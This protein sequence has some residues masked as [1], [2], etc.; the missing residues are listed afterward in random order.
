MGGLN[1]KFAGRMPEKT[2][3]D[4]LDTFFK[5]GGVHLGFTQIDRTTLNAAREHP[6]QY[7]SLCVRITGFSEYFVALSPE[8]QRDVIERTENRP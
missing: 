1:V 6:E 2:L 3:I 7:R 8:G 5:M 4:T